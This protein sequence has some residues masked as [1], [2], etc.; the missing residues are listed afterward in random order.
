MGCHDELRIKKVKLDASPFLYGISPCPF[1]CIQMLPDHIQEVGDVF[2]RGL[3]QM[4]KLIFQSE[5]FPFVN[6]QFMIAQDFEL[7]IIGIIFV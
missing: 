3:T 6:S 2:I 4:L 5:I 1:F 7:I